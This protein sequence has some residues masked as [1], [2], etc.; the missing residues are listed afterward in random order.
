MDLLS[1]IVY[2]GYPAVSFRGVYQVDEQMWLKPPGKWG[3]TSGV[4]KKHGIPY[5][6]CCGIWS[7]RTW[8][9]QIYHTWMLPVWL[10]WWLLVDEGASETDS[11]RHSG[12]QD[13]SLQGGGCDDEA[14][15]MVLKRKGILRGI[16]LKEGWSMMISCLISRFTSFVSS[17]IGR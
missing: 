3:L 17:K 5:H 12:H 8:M 9:A 14:V 16:V 2:C 13:L 10:W 1:N 4:S 11:F 15:Q 6:P 7:S